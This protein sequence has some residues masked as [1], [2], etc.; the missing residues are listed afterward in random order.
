MEA[1]PMN[2]LAAW[3]RADS[4]VNVLAFERNCRKSFGFGQFEE[5][6][7]FCRCRFWSAAAGRRLAISF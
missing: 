4:G 6:C 7:G 3:I 2:S 1:R 5:V